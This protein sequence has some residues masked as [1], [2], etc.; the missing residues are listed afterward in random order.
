MK[1]QIFLALGASLTLSACFFSGGDGGTNSSSGV[2]GQ[3]VDMSQAFSAKFNKAG[4]YG[5]YTVNGNLATYIE[6]DF[7]CDSGGIVKPIIDTTIFEFVAP[8]TL[9]QK[10]NG[11]TNRTYTNGTS[12]ENS[13]WYRA[14]VTTKALRLEGGKL[15]EVNKA[16]CWADEMKQYLTLASSMGGAVSSIVSNGCGSIS[17]NKTINGKVVAVNE[18]AQY[19]LNNGE[20]VAFTAVFSANGKTCKESKTINSV[21]PINE[22]SCKEAWNKYLAAGNS[23]TFVQTWKIEEFL[24]DQYEA[25]KD[26]AIAI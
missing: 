21:H 25:C 26:S 3:N 16:F 19:Q 5:S 24:M 6:K 23:A 1:K 11:S 9:N 10:E 7:E 13:D 18:T 14:N 20:V 15:F 22:T 17:Y 2:V 12:L 4:I 8:G